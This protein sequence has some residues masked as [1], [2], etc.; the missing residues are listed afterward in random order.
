MQLI[1]VISR[2]PFEFSHILNLLEI[3]LIF[4]KNG[5]IKYEPIINLPLGT[6]NR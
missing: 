1:S 5:L 3:T 6:R 4:L 2:L